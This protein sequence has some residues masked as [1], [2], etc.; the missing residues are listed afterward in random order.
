MSTTGAAG[1]V[2]VRGQMRIIAHPVDS[3]GYA[4]TGLRTGL[5]DALLGRGVGR[6]GEITDVAFLSYLGDN[7]TEAL[8]G[9]GSGN[10]G[11][12]NV[13]A[14]AL[15]GSVTNSTNNRPLGLILGLSIPL[16]ATLL[17]VALITKRMRSTTVVHDQDQPEMGVVDFSG[18]SPGSL[19]GGAYAKVRV[20]E[21]T[22][23]KDH[24]KNSVLV[25][26]G[27][28]PGSFH[29]GLYH[30]MRH[31]QR[32][33]STR[34][35]KCLETKR[36]N[37]NAMDT[38]DSNTPNTLT[39]EKMRSILEYETYEGGDILTRADSTL[40]LTQHHMGINVHKCHSALCKRCNMNAPETTFV[41]VS[42][43]N[44]SRSTTSTS[45]IQS[46]LDSRLTLSRLHTAIDDSPLSQ[47]PPVA[48][49][50]SPTDREAHLS[51]SHSSI[52]SGMGSSVSIKSGANSSIFTDFLSS[53]KSL[54]AKGYAKVKK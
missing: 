49:V 39:S 24:P 16:V 32:Y 53:T 40:G 25:G 9:F 22:P 14:A 11:G 27:D 48:L 38:V 31:G 5:K 35:E 10:T 21:T 33:L 43:I 44:N 51:A 15:Q 52:S 20:P 26:T 2:V 54:R 8:A 50:A 17:A 36:N 34:C 41:P 28:P 12:G 1:C 47:L 37:I 19:R 18:D 45:A 6:Q 3:L 46:Q 42:A 13:G 30:Y 7:E 4:V 23:E 29:D